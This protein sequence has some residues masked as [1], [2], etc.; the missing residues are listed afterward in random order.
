MGDEAFVDSGV[1]LCVNS[2]ARGLRPLV[3][4]MPID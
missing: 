1:R 3:L 4:V 2:M